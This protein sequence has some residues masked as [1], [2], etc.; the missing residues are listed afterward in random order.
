MRTFLPLNISA[1]GTVYLLKVKTLVDVSGRDCIRSVTTNQSP[2]T[3]SRL[4]NVT[5]TITM[6]SF[7]S[8]P[9]SIVAKPKP[10]QATTTKQAAVQTFF[11]PP[12]FIRAWSIV[13]PFINAFV[14]MMLCK[15]S[16]DKV[17]KSTRSG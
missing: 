5:V 14:S 7:N 10:S 4:Q 1:I 12:R 6:V 16:K 3:K 2:I 11:M 17:G 9:A 15:D 13:W 8:L